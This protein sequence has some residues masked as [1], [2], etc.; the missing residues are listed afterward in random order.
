MRLRIGKPHGPLKKS[1][2][3]LILL[4]IIDGSLKIS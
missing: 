4:I 1:N 3:L 2:N